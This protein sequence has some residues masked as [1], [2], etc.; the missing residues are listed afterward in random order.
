MVFPGVRVACKTS[1]L[2]SANISGTTLGQ[3]V[4]DRRKPYRYSDEKSASL[5]RPELE[6]A[7]QLHGWLFASQGAKFSCESRAH[8]HQKQEAESAETA[9]APPLLFLDHFRFAHSRL[10]IT[11]Y[12]GTVDDLWYLP[13]IECTYFLILIHSCIFSVHDFRWKITIRNCLA[14]VK[15][16]TVEWLD[17][18]SSECTSSSSYSPSWSSDNMSL[19]SYRQL[20]ILAMQTRVHCVLS[21]QIYALRPSARTA[22]AT[23][24]EVWLISANLQVASHYPSLS[25]PYSPK[26]RFGPIIPETL[27]SEASMTIVWF[28]RMDLKRRIIHNPK[29]ESTVSQCI[30]NEKTAWFTAL[31][32]SRSCSL[33]QWY[34]TS[35]WSLARWMPLRNLFE[36][37]IYLHSLSHLSP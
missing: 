21:L 29:L 6:A 13:H 37:R 20:A 36:S 31:F 2:F 4:P 19:V 34:L 15:N 14:S 33:L 9:A 7:K 28:F 25:C 35:Q 11:S 16:T 26:V 10:R 22:T 17:I 5:G 24:S 27:F 1:H 32:R 8:H 23:T 3:L 12:C 30:D 18:L